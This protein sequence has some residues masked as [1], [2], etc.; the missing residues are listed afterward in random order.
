MSSML[1]SF[2]V[3]VSNP[4]SMVCIDLELL[5]KGS[6]PESLANLSRFKCQELAVDTITF[7]RV[8]N[9]AFTRGGM[10]ITRK[11]QM[12]LKHAESNRFLVCVFHL[13]HM[14]RW[15]APHMDNHSITCDRRGSL[16]HHLD[17]LVIKVIKS[18][19]EVRVLE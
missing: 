4:R 2:K 12:R 7:R 14:P 9:V 18:K 15:L 8:T 6:M 10:K 11:Y 1:K 19:D 13:W 16:P 5:F 3:S 17:R